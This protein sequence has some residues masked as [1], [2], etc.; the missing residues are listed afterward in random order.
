MIKVWIFP[1]LLS[2]FYFPSLL[3]F[4]ERMGSKFLFHKFQFPLF[5]MR[6]WVKTSWIS[7]QFIW[8]L[9]YVLTQNFTNFRFCSFRWHFDKFR[10]PPLFCRK[11]GRV[12]FLSISISGSFHALHFKLKILSLVLTKKIGVDF[13]YFIFL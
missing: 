13:F 5:Q 6:F 12:F 10:F 3:C 2:G 9:D 8:I 1:Q 4:D 7:H 11:K